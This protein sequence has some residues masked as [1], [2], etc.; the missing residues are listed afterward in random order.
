MLS[1]TSSSSARR[2]PADAEGQ[3]APGDGLTHADDL[4]EAHR[5]VPER[6]WGRIVVV[7]LVLTIMMMTAWEAFWRSRGYEAGDIKDTNAAWAEQRRRAEG[8]A[9]VLI[10]SSRNLFDLDLDTWERVAGARPVQL[11]LEGTSPRFALAD[12]AADPMFHGLVVCDVV[13]KAFFTRFG[14][15][16]AA[17]LAYYQHETVSQRLGRLLSLGPEQLFAYIDAQTRPAE[18]WRRLVLTLRPG[19]TPPVVE[20][21]KVGVLRADRNARMWS[22]EA[23]DPKYRNRQKDIWREMFRPKP[24]FRP[25]DPAKV[26]SEVAANVAKIRARGGNVVFVYHPLAPELAKFDEAAFPRARY[27]DVLL[28]GSRTA[29][30]RYDEHPELQGFRE[31]ELSHM[32]PDQVE[33]YTAK[34]ARLVIASDGP[35]RRPSSNSRQ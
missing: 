5:A 11:S 27:W 30:V 10:G 20:P 35:R 7:A 6:P 17:A 32:A 16:G 23:D 24:G 29:G 8:P 15:G 12:L 28:R 18:L 26:V 33:G 25:P 22:V 14:G 4:E 9:T 3:V 1:S 13:P 2:V 31:P 19:Q 21:Y 34:F